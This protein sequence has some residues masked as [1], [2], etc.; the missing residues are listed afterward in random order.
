MSEPARPT[1]LK[2]NKSLSPGQTE[3]MT[4]DEMREVERENIRRR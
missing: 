2:R 3:I 1:L 4:E